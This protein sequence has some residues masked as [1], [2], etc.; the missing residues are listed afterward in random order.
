MN[1]QTTRVAILAAFAMALAG[2]ETSGG[3]GG[4]AGGGAPSPDDFAAEVDRIQALGPTTD[5]PTSLNATYTGQA[6]VDLVDPVSGSTTGEAF[7]DLNL[8]IDWVDGPSAVGNAWTG[9][10]TNIRGTQNG[11]AFTT[12]G[13]LDVH[14]PTSS[15]DAV[16]TTAAGVTVTTGGYM[17]NLAGQLEVDDGSTVE[18]Q[19]GGLQLGGSFFGPAARAMWGPAVGALS[20]TPL[21]IGATSGDIILSGEFYAER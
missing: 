14:S 10:A 17:I 1:R 13:Q 19:Y 15:A 3:G 2:C 4:G 6:R 16:P 12:T 7:A 8:A 9:A 20:D 11:T 21:P 5:M 18:T